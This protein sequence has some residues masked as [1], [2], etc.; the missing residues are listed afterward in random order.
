MKKNGRAIQAKDNIRRMRTVCWI[1]MA[2]DTHSEY[3]TLF[4][5]Q[6]PQW[7]RESATLS[8]S[9]VITG[10]FTFGIL[11]HLLSGRYAAI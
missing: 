2:T 4:A 3:V 9:F 11:D 1:T 7:L 8:Q 10:I 6:R 5:F